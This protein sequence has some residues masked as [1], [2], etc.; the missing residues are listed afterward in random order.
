MNRTFMFVTGIYS[1][2][3]FEETRYHDVF[4]RFLI[5]Y[6]RAFNCG[7]RGSALLLTIL[8]ILLPFPFAFLSLMH[9]RE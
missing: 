6:I 2:E 8:R 5:I 4:L 9:K 3:F 1:S 7:Y